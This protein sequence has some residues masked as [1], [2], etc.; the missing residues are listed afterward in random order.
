[1]GATIC[2]NSMVQKEEKQ[3]RALDYDNFS[4]LPNRSDGQTAVVRFLLHLSRV[5]G[6]FETMG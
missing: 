2:I 3:Q 6:H 4:S 5:L 1:M